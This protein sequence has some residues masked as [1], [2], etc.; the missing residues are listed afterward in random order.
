[1]IEF[2]AQWHTNFFDPD[3]IPTV[4]AAMLLCV[5]IGMITGPM[6]GNANAFLWQFIDRI[7]GKFGDKIDKPSRP[8]AD[9]IFRGFLI[10][11]LVIIIMGA[12]GKGFESIIA[13]NPLHGFTQIIILSLGLSVGTVW[14][15]L[16]KLYFAQDHEKNQGKV[17]KG[18]YLGIARSTRSDLTTADDFG[19]TRMG[20]NF[21][22]RSFDK[23]M[24]TPVIWF[25]IAGY[26]GLCLYAGLAALSWRFGKDGATKGFGATALALE[27]LLGFFPSILSGILITLAGLFT[28]TAKLH[29]GI[30]AWLGHKNRASYEQ[31]GFALS[32][33]AWSL[34]VSL[35]GPAKDL[36]GDAIKNAWVGPQSATAKNNHKHLRRAIY[37]NVIAHILF[38]VTLLSLYVW[39]GILG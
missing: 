37:I 12:M 11:T 30:A 6:A 2:L 9:L 14:F 34:N 21:A 31:G 8:Q 20:M 1:M 19:I 13:A 10:T 7:I 4:L 3:R 33:M 24:V 18:A 36:K 17:V 25:L 22:A 15:S 29:K 26:I 39:S 28:P 16:L 5:V 35:G 38:V 32:A 23:N 27:K